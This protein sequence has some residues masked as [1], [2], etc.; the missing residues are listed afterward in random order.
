VNKTSKI[1]LHVLQIKIW[2]REQCSDSTKHQ[3]WFLSIEAVY[4]FFTQK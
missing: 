4:F 1:H 2:F 3:T